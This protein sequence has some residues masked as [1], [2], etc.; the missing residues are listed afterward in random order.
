VSLDAAAFFTYKEMIMDKVGPISFPL[1]N[2]RLT[3]ENDRQSKNF[4]LKDSTERD[5]QEKK[6]DS[7]NLQDPDYATIKEYIAEINMVLS[8]LGYALTIVLE[9]DDEIMT[10]S[11]LN[12]TTGKKIRAVSV[13]EIVDLAQNLR[14][15]KM[16]L[17][18]KD[19]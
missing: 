16:T 10:I 14:N 13:Q 18:D 1:I 19:A 8:T 3:D 5:A 15:Q 4:A 17:I 2:L 12:S 11:I 7:E 6:K 9:N